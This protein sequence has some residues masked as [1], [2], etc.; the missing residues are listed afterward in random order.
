MHGL[1]A[2]ILDID[3]SGGIVFNGQTL[4]GGALVAGTT[5]VWKDTTQ[6]ITYTL[7]GSGA[8]QVFIIG[9][10]GSDTGLCIQGWQPDQLGLAMAGT[11]A[12]S[13]TNTLTSQDGYGDA[14]TGTA[15][16]D[17]MQGLSGNDALDGSAGSDLIHGGS[18]KDMILFATGLNVPQ[19]DVN[20]DGVYEDWAPPAGSGAVW[21]QGRTWGIYAST[22]ANGDVYIVDGGG[23]LSQDSP[24]DIVFAG[25]D[26]RVVGGLG[27]DYI[28]VGK[29]MTLSAP[30]LCKNKN[31]SVNQRVIETYN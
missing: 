29:N 5:N 12:P 14:L 28:D 8:N 21:T 2:T 22:D 7:K 24:S 25:D 30:W 17:L 27:D 23:Y 4:T 26:D 19:R 16:A 6:G 11:L 13:A 20:H 3:G 18:G 10:D 1:A 31:E 9:K 15:G